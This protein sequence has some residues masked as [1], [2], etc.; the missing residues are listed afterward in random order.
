MLLLGLAP[1]RYF[2]AAAVRWGWIGFDLLLAGAL[3]SLAARWRR[4]LAVALA[5]AVTVDAVVTGFEVLRYNLMM[6][7]QL[8]RWWDWLGLG[9][10]V[11]APALAAVILWNA[12]G[13]RRRAA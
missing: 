5:V 10:A 11:A 3:V 4:S 12:I 6:A 8:H 2:P 9:L 7:G 13:H 1:A